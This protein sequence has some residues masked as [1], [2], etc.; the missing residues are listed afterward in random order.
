MDLKVLEVQQWYNTT[1]QNTPGY[2]EIDE[3]GI[4]G[5]GT[6]RA[7][8][9]ALQYE[10]GI[11]ADGSFGKG[12]LSSCPT[13]G[14]NTTF[15]NLIKII[16]CGF[17]CKGYECGGIDGVYGISTQASARLFKADAG[18]PQEDENMQPIFIQAL[19]NTDA[20]R[21]VRQGKSYIREAQQYLN[22]N[23][24]RTTNVIGLIPCNGVADRNMS[25][26]IIIALQYEEAG[27]T[28]S[29]VD[30]VYGNNTLNKAPALAAGSAKEAYIKIAQM[31]LMMMHGNP[32]LTGVYDT[33]TKEMVKGFQE[34]YCLTQ[35]PRVIAGEIGRT[36][37]ASLLSSKGDSTRVATACDCSEQILS[38]S[39]AQKLKENYDI[40][41]RYLTGTVGGSK[42]K[43]LSLGEISILSD[44]GLRIF[45]IYQDGGASLTYFGE[46]QGRK[47]AEKAIT[48]ACRL[49]IP[50]H[51]IIYFA[52]DFD[53]TNDQTIERVI[54]HFRGI[55]NVFDNSL[56]NYRIGIY[57][58]RNVCTQ[59][60]NE[61]LAVSSFV[62]DM[63]TG[64]SGN[65]GFPLPKNWA[66]DQIYEYTAETSDGIKFAVDK[67]VN[68]GRDLGFTAGELCGKEQFVDCTEH[69]MVLE[70]DGYYNCIC[71]D[72]QVRSPFLQDEE[73]LTEQDYLKMKALIA[74]YSVAMGDDTYR[75]L[76]YSI[77]NAMNEIRKKE[78]YK[79]KYEYRDI[80]GDCLIVP[81]EGEYNS[82][83]FPVYPREPE[84]I[85][86]LNINSY[87]GVF[88]VL[89]ETLYGI[90]VDAKYNLS[91]SD[92]VMDLVQ[93]PD[94][95]ITMYEI[96][97][98]L[99]SAAH[100]TEWGYILTLIQI[101]VNITEAEANSKANLG[102]IG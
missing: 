76:L 93:N 63:S 15:E 25:K 51:T 32:G 36:T 10:L 24:V 1:Y 67:D 91:L 77:S 30:G 92:T 100:Q 31:C 23:Y 14:M 28:M 53:F 72:Y 50:N 12:T 39:K 49:H 16:Q 85:T 6:C 84:N 87:N 44:N 86:N 71:C 99:A 89:A 4:T 55:K 47:D 64:Y 2:V 94:I 81:P 57:G 27:K 21:L 5:A 33:D 65:M 73:I 40:V 29:G 48:A 68:S 102:D 9:R 56:T 45:P 97:K 62:S 88:D 98:A 34:F 78:A 7:L 101:G 37:W 18:F 11:D 8:I 80:N 60:C 70:E 74:L 41:G 42:P 46:Q 13:I 54:P 59:I 52:V 22:A 58:S 82:N 3:D 38:L 20:F 66:F 17:Y 79:G 96:V 90:A 35:D 26:A 75:N 95:T 43:N 61:E 19:L 83:I 69:S